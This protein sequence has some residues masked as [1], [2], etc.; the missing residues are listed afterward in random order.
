MPVTLYAY[1]PW[2]GSKAAQH[3]RNDDP[4]WLL[5]PYT[6]CQPYNLLQTLKSNPGISK[7]SCLFY[8]QGIKERMQSVCS[9][10]FM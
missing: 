3:L 1:H 2:H 6:R 8:L 10:L 7:G 5:S 4:L 9:T